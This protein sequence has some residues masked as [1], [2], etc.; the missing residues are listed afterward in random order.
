MYRE[1]N[2]N[3]HI[4]I[5]LTWFIFD[6]NS[7]E[8]CGKLG[9]VYKEL[10]QHEKALEHLHR[11]IELNQTKNAS[12]EDVAIQFNNL[13]TVLYK[14]KKFDQARQNYE[15]SLEL[16]LQCL[17]STH[18]DIAQSY[19][20]ISAVVYAQGDFN[21]ALSSFS[22]AF[23]IKSASLPSEHPSLAITF[24]NI[25]QTFVSL[26]QYKE[27]LSH[28]EKAVEISTKAL[29]ENH[30]QTQEFLNNLQIIRQHLNKLNTN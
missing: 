18:P 1:K 28:A 17:P 20:N 15:Q 9:L 27:A 16:R 2:L 30:P 14:Q 29:T 10:N 4:P 25:A 6:S 12:S 19:S 26:G 23:K 3:L 5:Q 24:N 11:A 22:E 8:S 21:R 7:A 13:G